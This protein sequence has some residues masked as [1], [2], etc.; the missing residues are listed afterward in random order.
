MAL[1]TYTEEPLI[2]EQ[3]HDVL[4]DHHARGTQ[5]A[6]LGDHPLGDR[7]AWAAPPDHPDVDPNLPQLLFNSDEL[8][9]QSLVVHSIP[10][11]A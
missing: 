9:D 4:F 3:L 7:G 2:Y 11:H 6:G 5:W 8:L 1:F 10:R